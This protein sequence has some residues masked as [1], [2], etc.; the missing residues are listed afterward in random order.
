[1]IALGE[2]THAFNNR[3]KQRRR[4]RRPSY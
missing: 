1:L 3:R 4:A 2:L